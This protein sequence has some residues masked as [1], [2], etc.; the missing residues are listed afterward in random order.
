MFLHTALSMPF[1]IPNIPDGLCLYIVFYKGE[2]IAKIQD[3]EGMT[4]LSGMNFREKRVEERSISLTGGKKNISGMRGKN[5]L[6]QQFSARGHDIFK[7]HNLGPTKGG[8]NHKNEERKMKSKLNI[9]FS[10][11]TLIKFIKKT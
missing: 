7:S 11:T 6:T 10:I 5:T 3:T 4:W 9:I 8:Q 1:L 2:G